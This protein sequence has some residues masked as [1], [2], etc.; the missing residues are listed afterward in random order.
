MKDDTM[1]PTINLAV[2]FAYSGD[3]KLKVNGESVKWMTT[4][5]DTLLMYK[6]VDDAL[7]GAGRRLLNLTSNYGGDTSVFWAKPEWSG[8]INEYDPNIYAG[9]VHNCAE[10]RALSRW[11]INNVDSAEYLKETS[12]TFD[13]IYVDP[14]FGSSYKDGYCEELYLGSMTMN[15]LV[16]YLFVGKGAR[17][18]RSSNH[19]LLLKLPSKNYNIKKLTDGLDAARDSGHLNYKVYT[20]VDLESIDNKTHKITLILVTL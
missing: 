12:E 5:R 6:M 16:D 8:V 17:L 2:L 13:V 7:H 4:V 14:P 20:P 11:S 10:Y 9:L 15:D 19:V 3:K 18:W 1:T